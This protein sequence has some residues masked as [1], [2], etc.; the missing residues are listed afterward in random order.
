MVDQILELS[1]TYSIMPSRDE[2]KSKNK[3]YAED[4]SK[5]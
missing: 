5:N 4:A 2:K 1:T 3:K